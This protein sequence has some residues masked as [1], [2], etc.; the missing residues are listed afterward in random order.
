MLGSVNVK[1]ETPNASLSM[2]TGCGNTVHVSL[3]ST[4]HKLISNPDKENNITRINSELKKNRS[5][6]SS[7]HENLG[8]NTFFAY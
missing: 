7:I 4:L 3:E 2:E 8:Q 1:I 5:S 6:S